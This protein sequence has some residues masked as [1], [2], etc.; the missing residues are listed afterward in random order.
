[1]VTVSGTTYAQ[2]Q[3]AK[4]PA[5]PTGA[6]VGSLPNGVL[7]GTHWSSG[8]LRSEN[9]EAGERTLWIAEINGQIQVRKVENLLVPRPDGFWLMGTKEVRSGE[10]F[11]RYI[12]A[13]PLGHKPAPHK[14]NP[15]WA[16]NDES[17]HYEQTMRDLLFVG[18]NYLSVKLFGAGMGGN[19]GEGT[20]YYVSVLPHLNT[21]FPT[22]GLSISEVLGPDGLRS[23]QNAASGLAQQD[24]KFEDTDC[25]SELE[26]EPKVW[27]IVRK[28]GR[29]GVQGN[30]EFS[31]RDAC[32]GIFG[33]TFDIQVQLPKN[34]V[35]YDDLAIGWPA[36][37]QAVKGAKDAFESPNH[38]FLI[39][40]TD[41]EIVVFRLD[42]N[43]IGAAVH[44]EQ[45]RKNEAAV[46]AQWAL[47]NNVS[48]WDQYVKNEQV[49]A[50]A[51][52]SNPVMRGKNAAGN[53]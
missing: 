53:R 22:E 24:M 39:A 13:A 14:L 10:N 20:Q 35:R 4:S 3:S 2:T 9:L 15:D 42:D 43:K 11:E 31:S 40:I 21:S 44:R 38:K 26:L 46:M 41:T 6:S 5:T 49:K 37:E 30:I 48:R 36:V 33:G 8:D 19:Y 29:W 45:L 25:A 23:F 12:W 51:K 50:E 16:N 32:S 27:A 28:Q 17:V 7:L 52:T 34:V 18:D 1:M 47:A